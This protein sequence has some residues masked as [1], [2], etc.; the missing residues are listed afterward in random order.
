MLDASAWTT[1]GPLLSEAVQHVVAP[2][3]VTAVLEHVQGVPPVVNAPEAIDVLRDAAVGAGL[4]PVGTVQSLGGEDFG[5]YLGSVPGAMARLGV[6]TPGGPTYDLHQGD[7][8]VDDRSIG[9]GA[10]V[11]A[12]AAA[13]ALREP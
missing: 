11:M 12:T 3:A 4:T 5:W 7:L 10:R 8:R 9:I 2:Y 13:V 1:I 6:R